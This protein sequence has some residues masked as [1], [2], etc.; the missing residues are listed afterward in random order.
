M[1]SSYVDFSEEEELSTVTEET[2]ASFNELLSRVQVPHLSS[3]EQFRLADVV[4][5]VGTV[6][7]H[8]RS[9]DENGSRFLVFFRQHA[10]VASRHKGEPTGISWREIAWAYHSQTQD[11]LVDLVTRHY[12]GKL[13]WQNA[14]ECGLFMW[15]TDSTA[16]VSFTI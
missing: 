15:L 4:E 3:Y 13:L 8:R 2:A 16:L 9:I 11:I 6:E 10:L 1:A 7:K 5:C 12:G 14:R